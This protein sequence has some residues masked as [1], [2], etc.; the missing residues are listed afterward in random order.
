MLWFPFVQ[1][2]L[3]YIAY[4]LLIS[5]VGP[6]GL[7]PIFNPDPS[8]P[9]ID[10]PV[11]WSGVIAIPNCAGVGSFAAGIAWKLSSRCAVIRNSFNSD[12]VNVCV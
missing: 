4:V 11:D 10:G 7:N 5:V 8:R 9:I 6:C 1:L 3:S 2:T 12:G